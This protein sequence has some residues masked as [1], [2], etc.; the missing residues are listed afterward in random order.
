MVPI[1]NQRFVEHFGDEG[2]LFSYCGRREGRQVRGN[3]W[4]VKKRELIIDPGLENPLLK[5]HRTTD[6]KSFWKAVH[7]LLSASI[8]N[9][10]V[11]LL[12]QQN[13]SVHL[14]AKWTRSMPDDFF[15]AEALKRCTTQS[16][17]KKL[18]RFDDFF[19]KS[20]Q[21]VEIK[22][23]SQVHGAAKMRLWRHASL[24]E[25]GQID[26]RHRDSAYGEAG[27]FFTS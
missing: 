14:I 16:R 19:R 24:L 3:S 9:H 17:R 25:K 12:L 15:A 6:V 7:R 4:L 23:L 27:G 26:L 10:C 2:G 18:L 20:Q 21:L 13:P 1:F 22:L 8:A 5:L 11:G